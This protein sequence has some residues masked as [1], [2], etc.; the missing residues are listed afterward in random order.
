[1]RQ[2]VDQ[3]NSE[4][5]HFS[6]SAYFLVLFQSIPIPYPIPFPFWLTWCVKIRCINCSFASFT[7]SFLV[8][9]K[10]FTITGQL[11]LKDLPLFLVFCDQGLLVLIL[12]N[13]NL[14][15]VQTFKLRRFF[16]FLQLS[17]LRGSVT[18]L[19][20]QNNFTFCFMLFHTKYFV[21]TSKSYVIF[22]HGFDEN[23]NHFTP[24]RT[25]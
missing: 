10:A 19:S 2:N 21:L 12:P 1:M 11:Q 6:R 13:T 20:T 5:G 24:D 17:F 8:F 9:S 15:T 14:L 7:I 3:N 22:S 4:Y 25:P 16:C 23:P 18:Y